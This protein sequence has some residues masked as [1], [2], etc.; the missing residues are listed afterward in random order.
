MSVYPT[1]PAKAKPKA[2]ASSK[3]RESPAASSAAKLKRARPIA[4]C[5]L[6]ARTEEDHKRRV[7]E[8]E[9][10]RMHLTQQLVKDVS[11]PN[12]QLCLS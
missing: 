9:L 2:A 4:A 7:H 5:D 8:G 11:V 6:C 3:K 12:A 10:C 1:M